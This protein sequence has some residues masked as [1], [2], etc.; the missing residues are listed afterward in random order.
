MQHGVNNG[1]VA[2]DPI[3]HP[4]NEDPAIFTD[5]RGNFHLLTN[6]NTGHRRCKGGEACGGHAWSRDGITW[7]DTFI[8][9]FGPNGYMEDGSIFNHT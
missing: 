2:G 6:V 9:A 5:P 3:T 7:S 1:G 4:E 8:G